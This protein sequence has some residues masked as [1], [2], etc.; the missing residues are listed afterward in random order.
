MILVPPFL[1]ISPYPSMYF[2]PVEAKKFVKQ[3]TFCFC[4]VELSLKD[5]WKSVDT[6]TSA[7]NCSSSIIK[8]T[9]T[10]EFTSLPAGLSLFSPVDFPLSQLLLSCWPVLEEALTWNAMI[11]TEWADKFHLMWTTVGFFLPSELLEFL[12]GD[13][14]SLSPLT[15]LRKWSKLLAHCTIENATTPLCS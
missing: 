10:K 4:R 9:L 1:F 5:S 2:H 13:L 15:F 7:N 6:E 3:L 8:M 11:R 12:G 14:S